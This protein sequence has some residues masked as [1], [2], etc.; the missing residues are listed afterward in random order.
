VW[1]PVTP[2]FTTPY[3][4]AIVVLDEGYQMVTNV[5]NTDV[6]QLAID[7]PLSVTFERAGEVWL[8]YFQP[9]SQSQLAAGDPS[10]R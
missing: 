3:A 6:D 7:L 9:S 4:P 1:R 5:I 2:E 10:R 8:P